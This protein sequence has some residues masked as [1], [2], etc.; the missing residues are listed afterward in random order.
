MKL[1][2]ILICLTGLRYLHFG[3][4][5]HRYNW[6][7]SYVDFLYDYLKGIKSAWVMTVLLLLPIVIVILLLQLGFAHG[8]FYVL[9]FFLCIIILWYCLW[10]ISLQEYLETGLAKQ[11]AANDPADDEQN[12]S[13]AFVVKDKDSRA[14]IEAMLCY[15]NQ[16]TFAVIFWFLLLGPFGALLYRTIAQLTKL[17]SRPQANLNAIAH[18]AHVMEDVLEWVPARLVAL[19]YVLAG[20]FSKG[21]SGWLQHAKDGFSSNQDLLITTGLGAMELD[22]DG[23]SDSQEARQVLRMIDRSLIIWLVII[24]IFTLGAWIY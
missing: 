9:E 21:F 22:P 4:T 6:F 18:C 2:V 23:E 13:D 7:Q 15:A 8:I 1:I 11:A 3:R 12:D 24:A 19:G 20:N 14:L 5:P 10:P 16:R 17:S